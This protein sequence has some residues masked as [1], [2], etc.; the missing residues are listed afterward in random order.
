[1]CI[2]IYAEG[3]EVRYG[4]RESR[5]PIVRRAGGISWLPWG[6]PEER[7]G[8]FPSG[9]WASRDSILA[10]KWKPWHPKPVLI[11]VE[12]FL[13]SS[14]DGDERW[15]ELESSMALQGLL[16]TRDDE[17]RVFV[18]TVKPPAEYDWVA[19]RWPRIC[20]L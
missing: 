6:R 10:G 3:S 2:A 11:R 1:M 12:Q 15:I 13:V 9:G 5:L 18:V 7:M 17:S 19:A 8:R 4:H 16:A 20:R 14:V